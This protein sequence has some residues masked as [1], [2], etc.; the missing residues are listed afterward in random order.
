MEMFYRILETSKVNLTEFAGKVGVDRKTIYNWTKSPARMMVED[1][2]K[3][4][5]ALQIDE[6]DFFLAIANDDRKAFDRI[7]YQLLINLRKYG[8][9]RRRRRKKDFIMKLWQ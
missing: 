8:E 6:A 4:A 3:I 9:P 2:W 1:C 5:K 7:K